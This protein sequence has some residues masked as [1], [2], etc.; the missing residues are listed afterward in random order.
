MIEPI[1]IKLHDIVDEHGAWLDITVN[2]PK[3]KGSYDKFLNGKHPIKGW[4]YFCYMCLTSRIN[5]ET[6]HRTIN[7]ETLHKALFELEGVE[8]CGKL[9]DAIKFL[10]N[11]D[12]LGLPKTIYK[13]RKDEKQQNE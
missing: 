5:E 8:T 11:L 6:I 9:D 7:H 1:Q 3:R 2:I 4:R 10:E 12:E 13:K